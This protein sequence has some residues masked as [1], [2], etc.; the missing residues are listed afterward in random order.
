MCPDVGVILAIATTLTDKINFSE[1][2]D[3]YLDESFIR[4]VMWWNKGANSKE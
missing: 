4:C 2:I 3:A 1:F